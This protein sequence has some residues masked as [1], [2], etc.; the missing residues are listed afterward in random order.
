MPVDLIYKIDKIMYKIGHI[1]RQQKGKPELRE[2]SGWRVRM[3]GSIDE[4]LKQ[5]QASRGSGLLKCQLMG[6]Q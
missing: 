5:D 3:W 6:A 1:V 4:R 2:P